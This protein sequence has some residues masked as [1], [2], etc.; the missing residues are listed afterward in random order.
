VN[1]STTFAMKRLKS[2]AKTYSASFAIPLVILAQKFRKDLS[3][4]A[5]TSLTKF[6]L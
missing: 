6:H 4:S 2:T 1:S 5:T 3:S